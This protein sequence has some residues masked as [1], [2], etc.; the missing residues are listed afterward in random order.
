[1]DILLILFFSHFFINL[2][3]QIKQQKNNRR[4]AAGKILPSIRLCFRRRVAAADAEYLLENIDFYAKNQKP[5]FW[6]AV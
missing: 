6:E 4:N 5:F 2:L 3:A 1:M